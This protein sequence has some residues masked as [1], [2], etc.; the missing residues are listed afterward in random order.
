MTIRQKIKPS[1]KAAVELAAADILDTRKLLGVE[2]ALPPGWRT[3]AR[4]QVLDYLPN[5]GLAQDYTEQS[6]AVDTPR[7]ESRLLTGQS[8]LAALGTNTVT[9]TGWSGAGK[10][11]RPMF[12]I[13][14]VTHASLWTTT[15]DGNDVRVCRTIDGTTWTYLGVITSAAAIYD[16]KAWTLS[17]TEALVYISYAG[18]SKALWHLAGI[19]EAGFVATEATLDGVT[20]AL[21]SGHSI[22]AYYSLA[23][24]PDT[25]TL[26]LGD[27]RDEAPSNTIL[28]RRAG[29]S[30]SAWTSEAFANEGGTE[31]HFHGLAYHAATGTMIAARGDGVWHWPNGSDGEA[32]TKL[33]Y[34]LPVANGAMFN[35]GTCMY[36]AGLADAM[37]WGS[38][39]AKAGLILMDVATGL[40]KGLALP[41][42]GWTDEGTWD[43]IKIGELI[44]FASRHL[45]KTP[46]DNV[47]H[48][49]LYTT[50]DFRDIVEVHQFPS[51]PY[52]DASSISAI[53]IA[54]VLNGTLY[55]ETVRGGLLDTGYTIPIPEIVKRTARLV[56]GSVTNLDTSSQSS[57]GYWATPPGDNSTGSCASSSDFSRHGTKSMKFVSAT[58]AV[59]HWVR[60]NGAGSVN[61]IGN[62]WPVTPGKQYQVN[63]STLFRA[64]GA[65]DP[66]QTYSVSIQLWNVVGTPAWVSNGGYDT[67]PGIVFPEEPSVPQSEDWIDHRFTVVVPPESAAYN[68]TSMKVI[69]KI[70]TAS[71][72]GVHTM[73]VGGVEVTES[74]PPHYPGCATDTTVAVESDH[75]FGM[76]WAPDQFTHIMGLQPNWFADTCGDN[77][78]PIRSWVI[79]TD[80]CLTLLWV[81]HTAKGSGTLTGVS[82]VTV[83]ADAPS[84]DFTADMV[85]DQLI[86]DTSHRAYTIARIRSTRVAVLSRSA[87][88]ESATDTFT[89]VSLKGQFQLQK[90]VA[91]G[92]ASNECVTT[93]TYFGKDA[94]IWL[95]VQVDDADVRLSVSVAGNAWEHV[96]AGDSEAGYANAEIITRLGS[97]TGANIP[98]MAMLE[99][100]LLPTTFDDDAPGKAAL[101]AYVTALVA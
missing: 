85:G 87:A 92:A 59:N 80:N 1:D 11:L 45:P 95:A 7:T 14:T 5:P 3:L 54:G 6:F 4:D 66:E 8:G 60:S 39:N 27:Y 33:R 19:T 2:G 10:T 99:D 98:A 72:G 9:G 26:L 37:L 52:Y 42:R 43:F 13:R 53:G 55:L 41:F 97:S 56:G 68:F 83:T 71:E 44:V 17:D 23:Q 38:Y 79:D 21:T 16:V 88:A 69:I 47:A 82:T 74:T 50:T 15:I 91:G 100:I 96:T 24:F 18:G 67:W 29:N 20:W 64:A 22:A 73:Y 12:Q 76:F 35:G 101:E 93:D 90:V 31:S 89:I 63:L 48:C 57:L 78:L 86:F 75:V 36:D 49:G 70:T 46:M 81:P 25:G 58:D 32:G 34:V 30:G 77:A 65:V 51:L 61:A 62:P 40:W 84:T 28:M 94:M